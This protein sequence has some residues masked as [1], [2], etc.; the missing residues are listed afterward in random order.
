MHL[1]ITC[2]KEGQLACMPGVESISLDPRTNDQSLVMTGSF[3]NLVLAGLGFEHRHFL[4]PRIA[5]ISA[6]AKALLPELESSGQQLAACKPDR[7]AVLSSPAMAPLGQEACL[8]ILEMTAGRVATLPETYL[9]LRH[10]PMS[11]LTADTLVLCILS[12]DPQ[13][14]LYE[15][16]LIQ[17]LREKALGYLVVVGSSQ[18]L[19]ELGRKLVPAV[20]PDIA[21]ELRAPFEIVFFQLLGYHLSLGFDLDPDNPSPS[22]VITRVVHKFHL[23]PDDAEVHP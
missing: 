18:S 10:G 19:A 7:V 1:A 12:S 2:N 5:Y 20:A 16:D 3:S 17:E 11:F 8:K 15:L 22:G 9:G 13:C 21:D 14:R 4:S 23:Y 6:K